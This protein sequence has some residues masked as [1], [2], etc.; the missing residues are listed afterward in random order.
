M[1]KFFHPSSLAVFG[2][3]ANSKNLG[4]NIIANSLELGF[5]ARIPE[6]F[7]RNAYE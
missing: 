4:K 3:A 2:V 6:R 7:C 1:R 5:T